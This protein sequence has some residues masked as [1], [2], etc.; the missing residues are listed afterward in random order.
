MFR[1][2]FYCQREQNAPSTG[3]NPYSFLPSSFR[4]RQQF[5]AR[6]PIRLL[7]LIS[8]S[9]SLRIDSGATSG[10]PGSQGSAT[11]HAGHGGEGGGQRN[12]GN[13]AAAL[14]GLRTSE[15]PA[16]PLPRRGR[17]RSGRPGAE[18][19][20]QALAYTGSPSAE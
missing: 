5:C 16:P 15:R 2:P 1:D 11:A 13:Q 7:V 4:E 3:G 18:G 8:Q 9:P 19:A 10:T 17:L 12:L 14:T 20:A 6:R